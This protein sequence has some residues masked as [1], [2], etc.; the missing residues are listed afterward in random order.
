MMLEHEMSIA[1]FVTK[2]SQ[3]SAM[4]QQENKMKIINAVMK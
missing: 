3:K 4:I 1:S 2:L